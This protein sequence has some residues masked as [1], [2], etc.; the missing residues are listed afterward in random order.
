MASDKKRRWR[1]SAR[2]TAHFEYDV[3]HDSDFGTRKIDRR[4]RDPTHDD[5]KH[6]INRKREGGPSVTRGKQRETSIAAAF[7]SNRET[8]AAT[9]YTSWAWREPT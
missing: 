2:D 5:D 7:K 4:R 1:L 3:K 9:E 6:I 8:S